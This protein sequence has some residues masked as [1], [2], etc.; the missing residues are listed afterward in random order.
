MIGRCLNL[1]VLVLGIAALYLGRL[2]AKAVQEEESDNI[3]GIGHYAQR[4]SGAEKR[5][6]AALK[7]P[8]QYVQAKARRRVQNLYGRQARIELYEIRYRDKKTRVTLYRVNGKCVGSTS[9]T[10]K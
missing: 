4:L 8:Y 3:S 5:R 1:L 2:A 10:E 6:M 7:D 9:W